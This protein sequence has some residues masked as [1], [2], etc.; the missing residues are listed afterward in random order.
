MRNAIIAIAL[1]AA[2]HLSAQRGNP[3]MTFEG[4]S[5]DEMIAAFMKE[6]DVAG[7]SVAIVQAPYITRATGYGVSDAE[8][9][10][11]VSANTVFDIAGMKNAFTAVAVMQL[12]ESDK[13]ELEAVRPL[14]RDPAA[15]AKLESLIE[16]AS[17]QSYSEFVRKN[18]FERLGLRHTFFA[19]DLATLPRDERHRRFLQEPSFIDP[20]EPATGSVKGRGLPARAIYSSATDISIWDISLAGEILIKSPELRKVLYTSETNSSGPWYFPGHPGLMIA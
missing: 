12:V 11:L 16:K 1:L 6:H 20:T 3:E 5:V 19:A 9:R 18:Q 14:L 7:M 8:K 15:Y 10:T 4:Q 2:S 17:G 13:L